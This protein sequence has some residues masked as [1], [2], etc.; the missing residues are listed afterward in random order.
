MVYKKIIHIFL[1][2]FQPFIAL[3]SKKINAS[4]GIKIKNKTKIIV[5]W[6]KRKA[7]MIQESKSRSK[8]QGNLLFPISRGIP[9]EWDY[10]SSLS[11]S[12]KYC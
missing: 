4:V 10:F 9:E 12:G 7:V 2:D 8:K 1:L 11:E 6:T 3:Y 5:F